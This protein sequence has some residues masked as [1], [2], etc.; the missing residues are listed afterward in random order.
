MEKYPIKTI[1]LL[2]EQQK[3]QNQSLLATLSQLCAIVIK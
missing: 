2:A 1:I 3:Q